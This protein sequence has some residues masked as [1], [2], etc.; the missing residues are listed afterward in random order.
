MCLSPGGFFLKI[1]ICFFDAGSF[2]L[3]NGPT[4]AELCVFFDTSFF[5]SQL[6]TL[7][8]HLWLFLWG[9]MCTGPPTLS[10]SSL[11][12]GENGST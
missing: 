7:C 4:I 6:G 10:R 9:T 8:L 11:R 2:F 1:D 5:F 12:S 3:W